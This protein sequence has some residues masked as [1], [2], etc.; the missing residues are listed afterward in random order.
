MMLF[1]RYFFLFPAISFI[2]GIIPADLAKAD[3]L[4]KE[5]R[6]EEELEY[7]SKLSVDDPVNPEI[8]WRIAQTHF[9]IADQTEDRTVHEQHFYPGLE[10]AKK[11][12]D[13]NPTS[14]RAN[15]WYAVLIGKIGMLEGTEQKIINSYEVEKFALRAIQFDPGYDGT[16]HVMGRWNFELANLNWFE[17]KIA[18]WVY[19]TPPEG[20]FSQ[21]VEYFKLAID[22]DPT[23]IRHYVW[24]GKTYLKMDN[25]ANA[26]S[27]LTQAVALSPKDDG[28]RILLTHAR[29]ILDDL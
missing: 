27:I 14:A 29:L 24:L 16:Y 5:S 7:L 22:A 19:E 6:F 10:A 20:S 28:D 13:I 21:A 25:P 8:L 11:A 26:E 3:L 9:D 1:Q 2:F 15:H 12:L 4:S 17:R 18:S 23:E